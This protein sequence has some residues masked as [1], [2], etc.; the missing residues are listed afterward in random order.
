MF[1]SRNIK[2]SFRSPSV[3][4][5]SSAFRRGLFEVIVGQ[6]FIGTP[7]ELS[8]GEKVI[9]KLSEYP[10]DLHGFTLRES[11]QLFYF[12]DKEELEKFNAN[13][14]YDFSKIADLRKLFDNKKSTDEYFGDHVHYVGAARLIIASEIVDIIKPKIQKQILDSHRFSQ[15][16][17]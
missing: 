6:L 17:M 13:Y 1:C 16:G 4:A 10:T 15:C 14:R 7:L 8:S 5:I 3:I 9:M 11:K 12:S 2:S